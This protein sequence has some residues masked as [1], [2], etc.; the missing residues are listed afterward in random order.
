MSIMTGRSQQER[1]WMIAGGLAALVLLLIGW[2]FFISP[3]RSSTASVKSQ[4]DSVQTQNAALETRIAGLQQQ[5]SKMDWYKQQLAA[6][7]AALPSTSGVPTFLRSL[8][9]LG[10]E[11]N[12]DAVDVT[13]GAP[14]PLTD[15]STDTASATATTSASPT[16]T[17]STSSSDTT[18]GA[19]DTPATSSV[20]GL[21]ITAQ[22]TGSNSALNKFLQQLQTVQPRAVLITEITEG[23]GTTTTSGSSSGN[24]L[25][26]TMQAFV[27]PAVGSDTTAV[28]SASV[29]GSN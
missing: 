3:Q 19:A 6:A 23:S 28:P 10:T 2:A 25:Q 21:P 11:T 8:Q 17:P 4:V 18:S 20:Y 22:V 16:D 15:T 7:N 5:N 27:A 26:L 29:S 1:L 12:T 24:S 13:V 14:T 9:K